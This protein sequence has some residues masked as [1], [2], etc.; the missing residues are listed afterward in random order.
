MITATINV[1][2]DLELH[3]NTPKSKNLDANTTEAKLRFLVQ[4]PPI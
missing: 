2:V 4:S 3:S 1:N